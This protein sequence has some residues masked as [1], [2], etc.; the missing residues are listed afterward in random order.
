M[1]SFASRGMRTLMFAYKS[2]DRALYNENLPDSFFERDLEL[3]GVS[4]VEDLL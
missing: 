1:E 3:L 4:G 2:I